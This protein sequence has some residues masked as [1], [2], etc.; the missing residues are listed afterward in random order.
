[1]HLLRKKALFYANVRIYIYMYWKG[2]GGTAL[3]PKMAFKVVKQNENAF[4]GPVSS[5]E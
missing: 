1:M 3:Y 5:R 4:L 2:R